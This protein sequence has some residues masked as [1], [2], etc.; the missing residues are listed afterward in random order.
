MHWIFCYLNSFCFFSDCL[1]CSISYY[2]L[3]V[4]STLITQQKTRPRGRESNPRA[5]YWLNVNWS[6]N[7]QLVN[8]RSQNRFSRKGNGLWQLKIETMIPLSQSGL[9]MKKYILWN[10]LSKALCPTVLSCGFYKLNTSSSLS[11][12]FEW[13]MKKKL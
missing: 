11:Q 1:L 8:S 5:Y 4:M 3:L 13:V 10:F 2:A 9:Y 7:R 6:L 12:L